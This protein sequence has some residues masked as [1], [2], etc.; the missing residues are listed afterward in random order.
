MSKIEFSRIITRR[1][2]LRGSA[3]IVGGAAALKCLPA[4]GHGRVAPNTDYS[5]VI[6]KVKK[7]LPIA[8]ALRDIT[9][10][11]VAIVDGESIVWSEGER[12]SL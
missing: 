4:F 8:L 3:T 11:S 5:S 1:D 10:A 9:G 6:E 7:E 2:F 12:K